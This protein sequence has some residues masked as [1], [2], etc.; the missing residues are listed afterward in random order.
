M[1]EGWGGLGGRGWG[2]KEMGLQ[3]RKASSVGA[4]EE[5]GV[6]HNFCV[7]KLLEAH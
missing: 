4:M 6:T 3:E 1:S 2:G 7:W 5:G